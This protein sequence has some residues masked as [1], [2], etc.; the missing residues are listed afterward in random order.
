MSRELIS[1]ATRN[2]FREVLVGFTL[3]E[4]DMV[5]ESGGITPR[6]DYSPQISGAR[7]CLVEKYYVN[8]NFS[9]PVDVRKVARA[10]GEL[11][12]QLK[13]RSPWSDGGNYLETI[14][15]LTSRMEQDGFRFEK[16]KFLADAKRLSPLET[17]ALIALTEES[18]AEHLE[19]AKAKIE[20]GDLA[21]AITNAYTLVEEFLKEILRQTGTTFN[22]N[23]GDIKVLYNLAAIPLNL[24]PKGENLEGHLRTILQGLKSLIAGLY[25][26]ANKASDRHARKYKLAT[27][28]AKLAVNSVFKICEFMVNSFEYQKEKNAG[29][30]RA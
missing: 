7:R 29:K 6:S 3:H 26:V 10:F 24:N 11:M 20:T 22:Q 15:R 5:F 14:N 28:H 13:S 16:G 25:E 4:I 1:K 8:I 19:K 21:G 12:L 17:P 27:H 9:D 23:E 30:T 2:D 18:I